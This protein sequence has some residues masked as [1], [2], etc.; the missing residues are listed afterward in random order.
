MNRS[1]AG[2]V[3]LDVKPYI[4]E[5]TFDKNGKII[6]LEV[7]RAV[8]SRGPNTKNNYDYE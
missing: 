6:Q 2:Q 3:N 7:K 4:R 8:L 5:F 1:A